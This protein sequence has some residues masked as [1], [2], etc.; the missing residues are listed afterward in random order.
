MADTRLLLFLSDTKSTNES[1][2]LIQVISLNVFLR[3]STGGGSHTG[4][5]I[6]DIELGIRGL[7][8]EL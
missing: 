7:A 1:M 4:S 8:G 3:I 6:K 2:D 5:K